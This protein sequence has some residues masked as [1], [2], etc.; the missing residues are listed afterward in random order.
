[1]KKTIIFLNI[2]LI[3]LISCQN[4]TDQ[5][6]LEVIAGTGNPGFKDG[7]SAE[8]FKP[9]RLSTYKNNSLVF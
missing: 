3:G 8:L 5:N 2:L 1:M 9:I 6:N 4:N 7:D